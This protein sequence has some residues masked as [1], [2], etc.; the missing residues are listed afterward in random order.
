MNKLLYIFLP[1][2]LF[3]PPPYHLLKEERDAYVYMGRA[4]KKF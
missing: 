4:G 3:L 1:F 2:Q